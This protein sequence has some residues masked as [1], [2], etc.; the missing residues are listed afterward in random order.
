LIS[1]FYHFKPAFLLSHCEV[2]CLKRSEKA[3]FPVI[4]R[5]SMPFS[6]SFRDPRW[7]EESLTASVKGKRRY[8]SALPRD[9]PSPL[10][11]RGARCPEAI[12]HCVCYGKK[13]RLLRLRL[14]MTERGHCEGSC[15]ERSEGSALKQSLTAS[16]MEKRRD[17]FVAIA[18]RNDRVR[19]I[20]AITKKKR[21]RNYRMGSED[22]FSAIQ[23]CYYFLWQIRKSWSV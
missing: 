8:P 23:G 16:V 13:T 4:A 11:L 22:S 18:P 2:L 1:P 10:S 15:P 9:D 21:A 6:P 17:C 5:G 12:S 3:V 14:A 19:S 20:L 7:V